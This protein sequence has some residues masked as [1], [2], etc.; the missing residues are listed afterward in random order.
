MGRVVVGNDGVVTLT[1]SAGPAVARN[2]VSIS[3][4][5]TG[6]RHHFRFRVFGEPL[7]KLLLR[8]GT[9]GG[10]DSLFSGEFGPG[11]HYI[12]FTPAAADA[13]IEF[14]REGEYEMSAYDMAFVSGSVIELQTPWGEKELDALRYAQ[15]NDVLTLTH[16]DTHPHDIVRYGT[17]SFG[18]I[19]FPNADGPYLD[20]NVDDDL[21]LT[22]GATEGSSVRVTASKP[23]FAASDVGRHLSVRHEGEWGWGIIR[24]VVSATVALLDVQ[25]AFRQGPTFGDAALPVQV[26]QFD[27][28][29]PTLTIP[30]AQA[31]KGELKY[32]AVG[33]PAGLLFNR[34]ELTITGTPLGVGTGIVRISAVD[35]NGDEGTLEFSF[36][37]Q[38]DAPDAPE[39][40]TP[41]TITYSKTNPE[42][43][44]SVTATFSSE[45]GITA[46]QWQYS[47]DSGTT[48]V[49]SILPGNNSKQIGLTSVDSTGLRYRISW[50]RNGTQEYA[51]NYFVVVVRPPKQPPYVSD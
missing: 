19:L 47:Q 44:D 9:E 14:V 8:I 25:R 28:A 17:Q 50:T 6:K 32:S 31:G 24:T 29:I 36:N 10:D 30:A 16:A 51:S 11:Q 22:L 38:S 7:D 15:S 26:W 45:D 40:G 35:E 4:A 12:E 2:I 34:T 49:D 3:E 41:P 42:V 48:W 5:D 1:P 18:I 33:V 23:L 13:Y 21:T 37:V 39:A 46:Y 43:G 20:E 27:V